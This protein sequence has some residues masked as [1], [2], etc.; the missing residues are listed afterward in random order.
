MPDLYGFAKLF[1]GV[2]A[3]GR[4]LY[5]SGWHPFEGLGAELTVT[6]EKLIEAKYLQ[7]NVRQELIGAGYLRDVRN[8][9][10][11]I[12]DATRRFKKYEV[13]Y[14]Q[15]Q[16]DPAIELAIDTFAKAC[17]SGKIGTAYRAIGAVGWD[18]VPLERSMWRDPRIVRGYF[19][20]GLVTVPLPLLDA[21]GQ[22]VPNTSVPCEREILVRCDDREHFVAGLKPVSATPPPEGEPVP[23]VSVESPVANTSSE[24]QPGALP[25]D[26]QL[27]EPAVADPVQ[28]TPEPVASAESPAASLEPNLGGRPTDRDLL[29]EEA[30]RRL[31]HGPRP[32]SLA[33]FG[34]ELRL[35][36][37]VHGEHRSLKTGEVMKADTIE[38]HVRPL[39]NRPVK[40]S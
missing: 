1:D 37:D 5:G 4:K 9:T 18:A 3:V 29:L 19:V 25:P 14:G 35:W 17:E 23:A 11:A 31:R 15:I 21:Q 6:V 12:D 34:R 36:L 13:M 28:V 33:A 2:D 30:D 40:T 32:P 22:C 16:I 26:K 39:W 24:V 7:P 8:D 10:R 27:E 38:D 20:D